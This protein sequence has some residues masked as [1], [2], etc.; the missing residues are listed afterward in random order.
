MFVLNVW[1]STAKVT[2]HV[3]VEKSASTYGISLES[4]WDFWPKIINDIAVYTHTA[5]MHAINRDSTLSSNHCSCG[6]QISLIYWLMLMMY[7]SDRLFFCFCF[8]CATVCFLYSGFW[9]FA[10]EFVPKRICH[11]IYTFVFVCAHQSFSSESIYSLSSFH[12]RSPAKVEQW[13]LRA[14]E[15]RE[16]SKEEAKENKI[17]W[18]SVDCSSRIR[19]YFNYK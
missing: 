3:E 1:K 7:G 12:L 11:E 9:P 4:L 13:T 14:F 15:M 18:R 5:F 8:S 2:H 16:Q 6:Q 10:L 17:W 19:F